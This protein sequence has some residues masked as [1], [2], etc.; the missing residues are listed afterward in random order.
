[1]TVCVP[2]TFTAGCT[3]DSDGDGTPDSIERETADTDSDGTPDWQESSTA[4]ADSD[5]TPDQLDSQNTNPCVPNNVGSRCVPPP[6]GGGGSFGLGLLMA[7][8]GVLAI[9]RRRFH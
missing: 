7:L 3:A 6:S 1:M 5:G 9:R 8:G 4:D 2:S